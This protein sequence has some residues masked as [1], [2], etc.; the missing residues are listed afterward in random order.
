MKLAE[1]RAEPNNH[2]SAFSDKGFLCL[3]LLPGNKHSFMLTKNESYSNEFL[4]GLLYTILATFYLFDR[5]VQ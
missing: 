3:N 4:I 5:L 1:N 2:D